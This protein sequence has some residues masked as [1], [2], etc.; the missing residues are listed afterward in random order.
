M[1]NSRIQEKLGD[2]R[3]SSVKS[4]ETT[5]FSKIRCASLLR[6]HLRTTKD[7]MWNIKK[8]FTDFSNL[9]LK[10]NYLLLPV[11]R[12]VWPLKVELNNSKFCKIF[13][14]LFFLFNLFKKSA[15]KSIFN[16]ALKILFFVKLDATVIKKWQKLTLSRSWVLTL[17]FT[18]FYS[19]M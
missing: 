18:Y 10:V 4:N 17:A 11:V 7:H 12:Y 2:S 14:Y 13:Y 15:P 9:T 6:L 8:S 16:R 3:D 5:P 19:N 1:R